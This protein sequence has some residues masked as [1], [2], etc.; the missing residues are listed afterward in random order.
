MDESKPALSRGSDPLPE[1]AHC[2]HSAGDHATDAQVRYDV[3]SEC[4]ECIRIRYVHPD[5][6]P[7]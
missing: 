3:S 6:E 5:E 2:G 7:E 4:W 1:C